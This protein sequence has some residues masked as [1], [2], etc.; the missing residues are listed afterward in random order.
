MR[1]LIYLLQ[2]EERGA[3]A[4]IPLVIRD[5][6]KIT[7]PLLSYSLSEIEQFSRFAFSLEQFIEEITHLSYLIASLG[8]AKENLTEDKGRA[9]NFISFKPLSLPQLRHILAVGI[10]MG[11]ALALFRNLFVDRP[12]FAYL[13]ILGVLLSIMPVFTYG[14]VPLGRLFLIPPLLGTTLVI[15][16]NNTLGGSPFTV[17]LG[18]FV[19]TIVCY[20]LKI[21]FLSSAGAV[22]IV[23]AY[24]FPPQLFIPALLDILLGMLIGSV[25]LQLFKGGQAAQK[26]EQSIA[27]VFERMADLYNLTCQGYVSGFDSSQSIAEL[28]QAIGGLLQKQPLLKILSEQ[29]IVNIQFNFKQQDLGNFLMAQERELFGHLTALAAITQEATEKG[30]LGIPQGLLSEFQALVETT[31]GEFKQMSLAIANQTLPPQASSLKIVLESFEKKL[32]ELYNQQS[33]DS[34]SLEQV[35]LFFSFCLRL[36]EIAAQQLQIDERCQKV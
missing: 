18:L 30:H 9:F 1:R 29:E 22:L 26:L 13:G 10:T 16:L 4:S 25:V 35:I 24:F 33:V 3:I 23:A 15:F 7:E 32:S 6:L 21:G 12:E 20:W 17:G 31:G 5:N 19:S 27:T 8:Q 14:S 11:F 34:Y 28:R 2:A 36:K